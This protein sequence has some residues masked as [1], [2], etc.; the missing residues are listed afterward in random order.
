MGFSQENYICAGCT[1]KLICKG[2][3]ICCTNCNFRD[4]SGT[5]LGNVFNENIIVTICGHGCG[6][7]EAYLRR[8]CCRGTVPGICTCATK[9]CLRPFRYRERCST[10][11]VTTTTL[12]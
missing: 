10:R 2:Y 8:C 6:W 3:N 5:T 9:Y 4:F 7:L 12:Q 1:T 11:P